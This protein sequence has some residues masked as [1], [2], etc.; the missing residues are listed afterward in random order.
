M[1]TITTLNPFYFVSKTATPTNL[2]LL[3]R[4][5]RNFLVSQISSMGQQQMWL[6][7]RADWTQFQNFKH[8]PLKAAHL[9]TGPEELADQRIVWYDHIIKLIACGERKTGKLQRGKWYRGWWGDES[10]AKH[11]VW[12]AAGGG[13]YWL[14]TESRLVF[15]A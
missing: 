5:Y 8:F 1:K 9:G 2:R 12:A 3:S 6:N 11:F 13:K 4:V 15:V 14:K 10:R 7:Y